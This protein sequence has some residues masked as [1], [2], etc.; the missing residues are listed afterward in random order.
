MASR[1]DVVKGAAISGLAAGLAA[2]GLPSAGVRAAEEGQTYTDDKYKASGGM[3]HVSCLRACMPGD[4]FG[5]L[6]LSRP[7]FPRQVTFSNI[8]SDWSRTDTRVGTDE[9]GQWIGVARWHVFGE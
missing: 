4:R 3:R 9:L 2:L 6:R 8:P 7:Q 1:V 5:F